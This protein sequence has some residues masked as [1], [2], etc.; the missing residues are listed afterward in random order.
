MPLLHFLLWIAAKGR[1]LIAD[2]PARGCQ[3]H[4]FLDPVMLVRLLLQEPMHQQM[5]SKG[6]PDE[7]QR[8]LGQSGGHH[9][10]VKIVELLLQGI[11]ILVVGTTRLAQST[12]IIGQCGKAWGKK[13]HLLSPGSTTFS[14]SS[15]EDEARGVLFFL[16]R[17]GD[18]IGDLDDALTRFSLP[19]CIHGYPHLLS[20]RRLLPR[21]ILKSA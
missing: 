8:T 11:G 20:L 3:Q 16:N 17:V 13:V 6:V 19:G 14:P 5:A 4:Q 2:G 21:T 7:P 10:H 9:Y 15:H 18:P 12:P 1:V